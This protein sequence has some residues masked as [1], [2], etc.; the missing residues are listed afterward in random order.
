[1][2]T[3]LPLDAQIPV[4]RTSDKAKVTLV[5]GIASLLMPVGGLIFLILTFVFAGRARAEI[6]ASNGELTGLRRVKI[7]VNCAWASI[8]INVLSIIAILGPAVVN[9]GANMTP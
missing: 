5:F 9:V 2:S 3:F 8:V 4:A 7:G 6:A 1:M